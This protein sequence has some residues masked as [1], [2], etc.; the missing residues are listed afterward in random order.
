MQYRLGY[1]SSDEKAD[2]KMANEQKT[3]NSAAKNQRHP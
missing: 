1:E 2:L 3:I